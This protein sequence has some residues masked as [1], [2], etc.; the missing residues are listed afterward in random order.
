MT[1]QREHV[2]RDGPGDRDVTVR[3]DHL[4]V[5]VAEDRRVAVEDDG[6]AHGGRFRDLEHAGEDDERLVRVGAELGERGGGGHEHGPDRHRKR[7]HDRRMF[8][9]GPLPLCSSV[10]PEG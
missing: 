8:I 1:V 9:L 5:D 10:A 7:E 3:R 4:T 2:L 6:V